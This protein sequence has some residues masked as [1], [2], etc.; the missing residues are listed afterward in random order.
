MDKRNVMLTLGVMAA[1]ALPAIPAL[2]QHAS[3]G[4]AGGKLQYLLLPFTAPAV[5]PP[6]SAC[7]SP[8]DYGKAVVAT[9]LAPVTLYVC[10]GD[11]KT[12]GWNGVIGANIAAT[13]AA[14]AGSLTYTGMLT[15]FPANS[16]FDVNAV[17]QSSVSGST[18]ISTTATV[19]TNATGTP[20][21]SGTVTSCASGQTGTLTISAYLSGGNTLLATWIQ[22]VTC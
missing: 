20:K 8:A 16:S 18:A 3:A 6:A 22:S 14:V 19:N 21:I 4:G 12:A 17:Y 1:L 5:A 10:T 7:A 9:N 2:A 11:G 15:G 13:A